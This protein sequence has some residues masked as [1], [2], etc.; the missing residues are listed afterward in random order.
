MRLLR[1]LDTIDQSIVIFSKL[2]FLDS[3]YAYDE[4]KN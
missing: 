1:S 3:K 2:C 4:K